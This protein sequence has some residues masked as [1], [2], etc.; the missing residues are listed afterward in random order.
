MFKM[1]YKRYLFLSVFFVIGC[2]T[3][4]SYDTGWSHTCT[5]LCKNVSTGQQEEIQRVGKNKNYTA[6]CKDT[7]LTCKAGRSAACVNTADWTNDN[8]P[9]YKD[10]SSIKMG[11][12]T[13]G[14]ARN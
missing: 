14:C 3:N 4:T 8:E 6:V 2:S 1:Q 5:L 9:L 13:E 12:C 10:C 11:D 7:K